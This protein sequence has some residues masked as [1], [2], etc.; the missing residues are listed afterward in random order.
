MAA[1]INI[2]KEEA[3]VVA[4]GALSSTPTTATRS[5]MTVARQDIASVATREMVTTTQ[6]TTTRTIA[7]SPLLNEVGEASLL[8][9]QKLEALESI[10]EL[11]SQAAQQGL[12]T[13]G[14][15]VLD[16]SKI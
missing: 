9:K 8:P 1:L 5:M 12:E 7:H 6:T 16:Q 4:S 11:T 2:V 14:E 15:T 13:A 3:S 10:R